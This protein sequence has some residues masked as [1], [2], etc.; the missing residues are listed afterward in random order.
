MGKFRVAF[1]DFHKQELYALSTLEEETSIAEQFYEILTTH[2]FG[3][4]IPSTDH[5]PYIAKEEQS[6]N[7]IIKELKNATN[8]LINIKVWV[9]TSLITIQ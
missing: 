1:K 2:I 3:E 7:S 9:L 6:L 4:S 8:T 5:Y